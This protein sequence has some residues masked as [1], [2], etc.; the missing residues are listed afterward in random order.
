MT[1]EVRVD[2]SRC[3]ASQSCVH[4]APGTFELDE[5]RIASV[6]D[7]EGE[8]LDAV[9]MAAE[10]CPTGAISVVQDGQRLA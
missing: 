6:I 8:P 9:V 5:M 2:P 10:S 4:A 3:I 7:P 1:L